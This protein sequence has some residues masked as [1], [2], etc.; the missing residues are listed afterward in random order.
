MCDGTGRIEQME[1]RKMKPCTECGGEGQLEYD[2]ER[3]ASFSNPTGYI[4]TVWDDC[5]FCNGSGEVDDDE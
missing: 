2:Y 1:L 3:P 4:D 5:E